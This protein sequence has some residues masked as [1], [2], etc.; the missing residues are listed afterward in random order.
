MVGI[1]VFSHPAS[2]DFQTET[3]HLRAKLGGGHE[4]I[5][6]ETCVRAGAP[7]LPFLVNWRSGCI[8]NAFF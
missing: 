8:F 2:P 3:N 6:P 1:R 5:L 7:R 4:L